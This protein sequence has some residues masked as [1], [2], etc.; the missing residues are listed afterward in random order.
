MLE[1]IFLPHDLKKFR[2]LPEGV[3]TTDEGAL[4]PGWRASPGMGSDPEGAA[5]KKVF[6]LK[7]TSKLESGV[8]PYHK[9]STSQME[10]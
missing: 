4:W 6:L 2:Y 1:N 9:G 7:R 3:R 5:S 10:F 8:E